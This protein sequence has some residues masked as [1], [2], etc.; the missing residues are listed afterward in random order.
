MLQRTDFRLFF[1]DIIFLKTS[2]YLFYKKMVGSIYCKIETGA[3]WDRRILGNFYL[4]SCTFPYLPVPCSQHVYRNFESDNLL[5]VKTGE[6]E[7][8]S[9]SI[10]MK[11]G[12]KFTILE[13]MKDISYKMDVSDPEKFEQRNENNYLKGS[14]RIRNIY[15]KKS[16]W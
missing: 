13:E 15:I 9:I 2:G 12:D 11:L 5:L 3:S 1:S 16:H 4:F 6:N 10:Q 14:Y 8:S 7:K